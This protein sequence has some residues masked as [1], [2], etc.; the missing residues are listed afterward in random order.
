MPYGSEETHGQ[1]LI[2]QLELRSWL[3]N[4][5]PKPCEVDR[6]SGLPAYNDEVRLALNQLIISAKLARK[7][8][9][10]V[11]IDL[12]T[13]KRLNEDHGDHAGDIGIDSQNK[14]VTENMVIAGEEAGIVTYLLRRPGTRS[15]EL[16]ALLVGSKADIA[17]V[18]EG[19]NSD[20]Q[21][22]VGEEKPL[23]VHSNAVAAFSD[24]LDLEEAGDPEEVS[25]FPM[26][27]LERITEKR[28]INLKLDRKLL[29]LEN[30]IEQSISVPF[31]T[32]VENCVEVFSNVGMPPAILKR[33]LEFTRDHANKPLLERL[34]FKAFIT[35]MRQNL[36]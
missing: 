19:L 5:G 34:T 33:L 7:T 26:I 31:D 17:N 27:G 14:R 6:R 10:V 11:K 12:E 9:A 22:E 21:I 35:E 23:V 16:F 13:L 20:F 29:M 15:D 3:K 25:K 32:F 24:E 18:V 28:L 36:N 30:L 4:E 1:L 8:A 2:E